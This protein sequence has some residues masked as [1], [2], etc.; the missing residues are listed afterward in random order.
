MAKKRMP[1]KRYA[2]LVRRWQRLAFKTY[3]EIANI[4]QEHVSREAWDDFCS[5]H[6]AAITH[7]HWFTDDLDETIE[8]LEE[9]DSSWA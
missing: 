9:D 1:R 7:N 8:R 3:D 4:I 2:M 6:D 5:H